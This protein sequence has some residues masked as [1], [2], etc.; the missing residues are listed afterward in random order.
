MPTLQL[1]TAEA[2]S[3]LAAA[4]TDHVEEIDEARRVPES[5]FALF[6]ESGLMRTSQPRRWGGTE[7]S[8]ID[9]LQAVETVA[10]VSPSAAWTLGVYISHNWNLALFSDDA[11]RDVWGGN[12]EAIACTSAVGGPPAER[13]SGG[14][15][16]KAGKWSFLSGIHNTDW[17]V[18]NSPLPDPANP[19]S[20]QLYSLLVPKGQ[21]QIIE[22]WNTVGLAGTGTCSATLTDVFVP[23]HRILSFTAQQEGTTPGGQCHSSPMYRTPLDAIWP[24]YLAVPAL[25]AASGLINSWLAYTRDRVHAYTR[26]PSADEAF[27]HFRLA[28]AEAKLDSA[29]LMFYRDVDNAFDTTAASYEVDELRARNRR[30]FAYTARAAA[31]V[32]ESM[33]LTSG[34]R[35]LS[36]SN[37]VQRFW[38][39]THAVTQHAMFE[40]ERSLSAWGR[41]RLGIDNGTVF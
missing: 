9:Q 1:T 38:R 20:I 19:D 16:I 2:A 21:Y 26:Q 13:V 14:A 30:D 40:Y 29:R 8:F 17:I 11:Q 36:L 7:D 33:F 3:D 22:D 23:D 34:A 35:S 4:L 31:E 24:A 27:K 28:E 10:E 39:D 37:P 6:V 32:V 25:G 18:V 15:Q 5:V 41:R 12:P